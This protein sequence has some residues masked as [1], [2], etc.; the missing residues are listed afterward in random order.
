M[1]LPKL[2]VLTPGTVADR[3][4][5]IFSTELGWIGLVARRNVLERL[6][7]G[8]RTSRRARLAISEP[9]AG[10][11]LH[12][13]F[14]Q[15]AQRLTEYANGACDDFRDVEVET[16][17]LTP[18]AAA[19]AEATRQIPYGETRSYGELAELAGRPGAARA[20][21][22]VMAKNRTPLIVPCH[23]VVGSGGQLGGFSAIDGLRMKR[24]LLDL[25][26]ADLACLR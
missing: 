9:A 13:W 5:A 3:S 24:R 21:G 19:I 12:P 7:F 16:S 4:V 10:E 8:H 26:G 18:F 11:P 25:E 22:G 2:D 17:H 20:V 14:A 6:S 23:R 1:P 15:L